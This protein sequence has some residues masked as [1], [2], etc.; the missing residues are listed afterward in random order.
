M[1]VSSL[2]ISAPCNGSSCEV[3]AT[4]ASVQAWQFVVLALPEERGIQQLSANADP[5][6]YE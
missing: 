1:W 4:D 3:F 2:W 6:A 5:G